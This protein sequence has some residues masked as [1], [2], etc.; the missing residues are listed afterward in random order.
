[1]SISVDK[2]TVPKNSE[3][4]K[5]L[6]GSY[7]SDSYSFTSNKKD[8]VSLQ[9]WLDHASKTPSWVNFFM[10]SRN[11]IVSLFGLKDLGALG[12]L[13]SG[14]LVSEYTIGDRVGIFTLLFLSDNE[15]ILG[16]S[17]KHLNVKVSVYKES[18][19]S[20]IIS[21]STVVQVHN[22][23]GKIYMLFVKPLH[24][25]IVPASIKRAESINA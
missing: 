3:L 23:V 5:N 20:N 24:K 17:D 25:L 10:S 4:S 18:T 1:M 12:D 9:I 15:V 8:R 16:D 13:N 6:N 22:Y 19:E 11:K 14:K 21:I 7:F 2:T